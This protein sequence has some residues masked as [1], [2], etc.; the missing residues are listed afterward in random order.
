MTIWIHLLKYKCIYFVY[1]EMVYHTDILHLNTLQYERIVNVLLRSVI[2]M[3]LHKVCRKC[4]MKWYERS[5]DV[6]CCI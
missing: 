6:N 4:A 5:L 3:L 2:D 1:Y